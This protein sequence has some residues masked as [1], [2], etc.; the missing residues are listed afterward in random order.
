MS[1][2]YTITVEGGVSIIDGKITRPILDAITEVTSYFK[3]G[4]QFS[5][6]FRSGV[7]DG[8]IRLFSRY[9][10][11]FPTGLLNDVVGA[12][13]DEGIRVQIDDKRHMP[14]IPP[15]PPPEECGLIGINF[16]HPYDYQV[17]VMAKAI[18]AKRGILHI[19]TNGGKTEIA[20]LISQCLRLPTLFLVPGKDLL[21]QTADRFMHRLGLDNQEVGV[22]GDGRW[23]VGDWITIATVASLHAN[24][25][26]QKCQDLLDQTQLLFADECHQVGAD[27]WFQVMQNCNA[28][29]RFGMS[30]TPLNRTDG[31]DLRL[32]AVTGP[33]ITKIRNKYLIERGISCKVE[34]WML[35]VRKPLG[36]DPKTPYND[37]Y[38][39]GIVENLWRNRAIAILNAYFARQGLQSIVLIRK[40]DHGKELDQRLWTVP[41]REFVPHQFICGREP[42]TVRQQALKDFKRGDL[43]SVISTKIL[44]QGI[45][46]PC[47]D[48]LFMGGGGESSIETLQKVGRGIR[49]GGNTNKLIVVD[50]ADFTNRHLLKHSLQRLKDY[51]D[52][53]CFTIKQIDLR[54]YC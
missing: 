40:I 3:Q 8:R 32:V 54:D 28:Y 35:P 14:S 21:H 45:D 22:I 7:W 9:R 29:F 38:D 4:Y 19:A 42:T 37:A 27:T 5:N 52:E 10:R 12:L 26:K 31:A 49:T 46:V 2:S 39:I 34:V 20:C 18:L 48:V 24:L 43:Q 33:I 51:K 47:I 41:G 15:I 25:K 23:Q 44:N 11:S 30:G 17:G 53:D 6:R 36:I 13:K 1:S 16:D 50:F